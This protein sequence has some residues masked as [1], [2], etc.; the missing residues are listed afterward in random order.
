MEN[1]YNFSSAKQRG[2]TW[3]TAE[4]LLREGLVKKLG[5]CS[6]LQTTE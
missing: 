6:Y 4:E 2:F 5:E 3:I 1:L